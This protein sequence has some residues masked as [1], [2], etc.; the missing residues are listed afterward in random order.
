MKAPA[1][2]EFKEGMPS[3]SRTLTVYSYIF[4]SLDNFSC[5]AQAS[6]EN[7]MKPN[8]TSNA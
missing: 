4:I 5:G 1:V 3:V 6:Q 7:T 8:M 2:T